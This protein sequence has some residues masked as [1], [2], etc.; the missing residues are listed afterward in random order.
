MLQLWIGPVHGGDLVFV[1]PPQNDAVSEGFARGYLRSGLCPGGF[2]PLIKAVAALGGQ[3]IEI[4]GDVT[5]DGRP[6]ANSNLVSQDGQ[7]RPLRPY[8]GGTVPSGFLFL[9]SPFPGSWDSR[10]FGPVPASGVLGLA[11]PVLTYAP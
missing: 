9:H 3:R 2:G 6:I 8:G 11:E 7:G 5:I 4:A 10:Y 1:C